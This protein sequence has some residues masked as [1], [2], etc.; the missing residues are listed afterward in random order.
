MGVEGMRKSLRSC[1]IGFCFFCVLIMTVCFSSHPAS[2][3]EDIAFLPVW[4]SETPITINSGEAEISRYSVEAPPFEIKQNMVMV[5][6]F[7][8]RLHT[9]TPA[10]WNEYLGIEVNGHL[11]DRYT[12]FSGRLSGYNRLINRVSP[13]AT[14]L[15]EKEWWA[16]R[17]NIPVLLV[18]FGD[19]KNLD[20]RIQNYKEEGY[21]YVLNISDVAH[22]VEVGADN[23]I[24]KAEKNRITFINTYLNKYVPGKV[25]DN[26]VCNYCIAEWLAILLLWERYSCGW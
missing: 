9:Q 5:M 19:G 11:L 14:T 13:L 21:C 8:A 2:V 16:R 26:E 12:S 18:Y 7:K 1:V 24:E 25:I 6:K 20:E 15:G 17:N 3:C 4:K 22:Y 10:G 23:R